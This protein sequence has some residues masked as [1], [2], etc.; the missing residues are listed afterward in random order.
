MRSKLFSITLVSLLFLLLSGCQCVHDW[1]DATC[2]A[3]KICTKCKITEGE[4]LGHHWKSATCTSPKTCT[5]CS[6]SEGEALGHRFP[7]DQ[8]GQAYYGWT[9]APDT[10]MQ[11]IRCCTRCNEITERRQATTDLTTTTNSAISNHVFNFTT[12]QLITMLE[13]AEYYKS[14]TAFD[15]FFSLN[16]GYLFSI[17][18]AS[19]NYT[20]SYNSVEE[21]LDHAPYLFFADEKNQLLTTGE[22]TF[23]RIGI[24]FQNYTDLPHLCNALILDLMQVCAPHFD[25]ATSFIVLNTMLYDLMHEGKSQYGFG[26]IGM[27][28]MLEDGSIVFNIFIK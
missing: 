10:A 2:T 1:T 7:E 24:T 14:N 26:S 11:L 6:L 17:Y 3:P 21:Y 13:K 9:V 19:E 8:F 28:A 23:N 20:S 4:Q 16:S 12:G 18:P 25:E 5:R 27:S 22:G 15:F